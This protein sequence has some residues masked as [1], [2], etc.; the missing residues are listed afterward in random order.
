MLETCLFFNKYFITISVPIDCEWGEYG[1]WTQCSKSCN[2]GTQV[3]T[4]EIV[5]QAL[6]GGEQCDGTNTDLQLCN[7]FPCPSK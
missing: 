6:N 5:T 3:R 4:R 1:N 7:E 2:G